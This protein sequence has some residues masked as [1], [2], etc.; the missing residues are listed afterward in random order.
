MTE[1]W[2]RFTELATGAVNGL[3]EE[4]ALSFTSVM[5]NFATLAQR[6]IGNTNE[7]IG[8]FSQM[9]TALQNAMKGVETGQ[10]SYSISFEGVTARAKE[11]MDDLLKEFWDGNQKAMDENT[12]ISDDSWER[13]A[14]ELQSIVD[15]YV[16]ATPD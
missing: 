2:G 3:D 4:S 1:D 11:E 13:W 8:A 9:G 5:T 16:S 15:N 12:P 14:K 6:M 10:Y 7:V